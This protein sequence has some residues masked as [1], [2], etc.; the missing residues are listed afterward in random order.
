[1]MKIL[2]DRKLA[3]KTPYNRTVIIVPYRSGSRD[4]I[5]VYFDFRTFVR[6]EHRK[7]VVGYLKAEGFVEKAILG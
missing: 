1:M 5:E 4:K 3:V 7:F 6:K 2:E